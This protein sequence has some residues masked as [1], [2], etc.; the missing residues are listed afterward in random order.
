MVILS[1]IWIRHLCESTASNL[2][3]ESSKLTHVGNAKSVSGS[4]LDTRLRALYTSGP[5]VI[6]LTEF[7]NYQNW[8][9]GA[10]GS[11]ERFLKHIDSI[12]IIIDN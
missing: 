3:C 11:N 10:K 8:G 7:Y 12:K 2:D 6:P 4:K 5:D 9:G 1:N